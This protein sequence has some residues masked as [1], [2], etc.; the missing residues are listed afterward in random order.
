MHRLILVEGIPGAGKTTTARALAALLADRGVPA[1]AHLEGQPNPVDLAWH[2]WLP[3]DAFE[4]V[5]AAHPQAAA[6]LRRCAWVGRTGVALAYTQVDPALAGPTWPALAAELADHEPFEGRLAPEAFVDLLATRWAELG[7]AGAPGATVLEAAFLQDT[8]V[9]L[10]LWAQW[11]L[12]RIEPALRRLVAAV[13]P[14]EP[15]VV[16]LTVTDPAAVVQA[17]AASRVDDRG[18]RWW[19]QAVESYISGAPWAASRGASGWP[20]FL[21][22]L[23]HRLAVEDALRARLPVAWVDLPSPAGTGED[24]SAL[25]ATLARLADAVAAGERVG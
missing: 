6:E 7:A 2:W 13:A 23:R 22:F 12:D 11:D 9:E 15:L 5:L 20:A 21:A 24:W 18:E 25:D 16:R 10:L 17:A 4:Q 14:L 3:G 8:L 1:V 19:A